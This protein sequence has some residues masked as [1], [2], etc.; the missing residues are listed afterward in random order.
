MHFAKDTKTDRKDTVNE[1]EHTPTSETEDEYSQC[2][3][4]SECDLRDG[5]DF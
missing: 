3:D 2:S 1:I 5:L 4:L